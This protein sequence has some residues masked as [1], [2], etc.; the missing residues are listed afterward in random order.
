MASIDLQKFDMDELI[1]LRDDV[2]TRISELA[3]SEMEALEEK[4][5]RLQ[6]FVS[7]KRGKKRKD[8]G[9]KAPAKFRDPTSGETW[10]GRGM[11]PRWLKAHEDNG[12]SRDEFAL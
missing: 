3:A 7:S 6:P 12:R 10:S 1:S 2:E 5:A 11:T 8:A 4:M 9:T